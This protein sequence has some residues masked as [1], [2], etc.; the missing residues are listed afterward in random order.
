[1]MNINITAKTM[2]RG[3]AIKIMTQLL[4]RDVTLSCKVYAPKA[5]DI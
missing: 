5:D 2:V 1:M 3:K 4:D